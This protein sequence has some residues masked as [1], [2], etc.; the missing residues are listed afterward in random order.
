MDGAL[1]GGWQA[2]P[3]REA[4]W[5]ERRRGGGDGR[6]IATLRQAADGG[7]HVSLPSAYAHVRRRTACRRKAAARA[8]ELWVSA[9]RSVQL[10]AAAR[11]RWGC[12]A[13]RRLLHRE[14]RALAARRA[15]HSTGACAVRPEDRS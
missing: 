13:R 15:R 2:R 5:H 11:A 10:P 1:A 6:C 12:A 14:R 7:V 9:E 8:G 3:V 4:A